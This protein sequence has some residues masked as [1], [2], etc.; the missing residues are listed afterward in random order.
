MNKNLLIIPHYNNPQGL[1]NS[2]KSIGQNEKLDVLIID[3]GS[4]QQNIQETKVLNSKKFKG[5]IHFQYCIRNRGIEYVLNDAIDY[6]LEKK[7][8]YISRLDCGDLCVENRFKIQEEF[9]NKN[10]DY[11]LV[12]SYVKAVDENK[13]F[14]FNIKPAIID[15]EIRKEMK[16]KCSFIHPSVM[17][18]ADIIKEVGKYPTDYKAAE[19]FAFFTNILKKYKGKN[20]DQVLVII[21]INTKGISIQNRNRQI[22]SKVRILKENFT[23]SYVS[24]LGLLKSYILLYTPNRFVIFLKKIIL[25]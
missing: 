3:D 4:N 1:I 14:L 9:L 12:G 11:A 13:N 24:I 23:F 22:K 19:D 25:K 7:Y 8:K 17:F 6:A 21:E 5:D 20:I 10:N 18:K 2:I 15:K 16:S